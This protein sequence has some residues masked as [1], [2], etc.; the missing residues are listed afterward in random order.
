MTLYAPNFIAARGARWVIILKYAQATHVSALHVVP[1]LET[2]WRL[3]MLRLAR[4]VAQVGAQEA[5]LELRK[6]SRQVT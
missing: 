3:F 6:C 5:G 2:K 4:R 1:E